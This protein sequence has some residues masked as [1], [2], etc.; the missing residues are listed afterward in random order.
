M[1]SEEEW[2]TFTLLVD[3]GWPGAFGE[4]EATAWR[5]LLDPYEP[6]ACVAALQRLVA[7]GGAFRPSVAELV[8]EI[9]S[10]PTEP[11]FAEMV[12]LVYGH[13]HGVLAA[14]VT[15]AWRTER[16]RRRLADEAASERARDLHPLVAAFV[17]SMGVQRLREINL[18][19]PDYGNA[20]RAQLKAEWEDFRARATQRQAHAIAAGREPRAGLA[21]FD[22]LAA[23]G[24]A[25]IGDGK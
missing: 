4:A 19:D 9:H 13:P 10:D 24:R 2:L 3:H 7:K 14:R 1:W 17:A 12:Q 21:K 16:E 15:G 18:D 23:L 22:P 8:A 25:Q 11:G 20:R 6:Q 5:R